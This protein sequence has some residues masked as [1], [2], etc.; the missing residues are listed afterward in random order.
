MDGVGATTRYVMAL[1]ACPE[2]GREVSSRAEACP[3]CAYPVAA[4]TPSAPHAAVKVPRGRYWLKPGLSI[5]ARLL[6]GMLFFGLG[7]DGEPVGGILGG[8]VIGG[9]ALPTWYRAVMRKRLQA[10]Q[11]DPELTER[12][13]DRVYELEH[14][15]R[16]ELADLE[17]R[18][19]FAER[20]LTKQRDQLS[21]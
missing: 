9:S 5:A 10:P 20:L 8:L 17:E 21:P 19:E 1:I 15:H 3:A 6:A 11:A 4:G 13:E 16:E 18:L 2:C 12:L 7:A 14:R